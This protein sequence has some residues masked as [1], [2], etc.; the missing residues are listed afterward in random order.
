MFREKKGKSTVRSRSSLGE[1]QKSSLIRP[2]TFREQSILEKPVSAEDLRTPQLQY[3]RDP[4]NLKKIATND[5]VKP[6]TPALTIKEL[7]ETQTPPISTSLNTVN[8]L[9]KQTFNTQPIREE[10]TLTQKTS[11]SRISNGFVKFFKEISS[12]SSKVTSK[13]DSPR[14]PVSTNPPPIVEE[15]VG[16]KK[17]IPN[18][19]VTISKPEPKEKLNSGLNNSITDISMQQPIKKNEPFSPGIQKTLIIP[20]KPQ[21][22]L[23]AIKPLNHELLVTP[24]RYF[25]QEK[26]DEN[27]DKKELLI[28]EPKRAKDIF[29]N[30]KKSN[31][32]DKKKT[33]NK[34]LPKHMQTHNLSESTKK[35]WHRYYD[36][37]NFNWG[38]SLEFIRET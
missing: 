15:H 7:N 24:Q 4:L 18:P 8:N 34:A 2:A 28:D 19:A 36:E 29:E 1:R 20:P 21:Q 33:S 17:D 16:T 5:S 32:D 35:C 6:P 38:C 10:S 12:L 26:K 25:N 23:N 22:S 37:V 11:S 31:K 30:K 27:L 9:D 3:F 13:S 14:Q